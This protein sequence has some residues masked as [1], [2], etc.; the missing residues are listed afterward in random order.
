MIR[1]SGK[2]KPFARPSLNLTRSLRVWGEIPAREVEVG[3]IVADLGLVHEVEH[4]PTLSVL[5]VGEH[6]PRLFAPEGLL[7]VFHLPKRDSD[8]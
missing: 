4:S 1:G 6:E 3:D 5:R 7:R 8:G 2:P